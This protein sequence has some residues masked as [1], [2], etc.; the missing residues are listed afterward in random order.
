M[1][2]TMVVEPNIA[3]PI[4]CKTHIP[5]AYIYTTYLYI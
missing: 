3:V 4:T 2:Y 5:F 1:Y